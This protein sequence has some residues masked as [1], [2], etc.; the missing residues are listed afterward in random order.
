M[1]SN[2]ISKVN[3]SMDIYPRFFFIEFDNLNT[4]VDSTLTV[5]KLCQ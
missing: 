2:A 5:N 4:R 3:F 1:Q